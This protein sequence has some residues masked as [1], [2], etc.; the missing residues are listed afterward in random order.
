M[1]LG[2]FFLIASVTTGD[3]ALIK[4]SEA[5]AR[6]DTYT[7]TIKSEGTAREEIRYFFRKPGWIRMEFEEPHR[8]AVLV[9]NPDL[10]RVKL[11]PFAF[12]KYLVM[13]LS[14]EDRLIRSSKGHTVD[15]S[16]IG[17]LLENVE[18]LKDAGEA[19]LM[20][21]ESLNGRDTVVLEV[22]GKEGKEVNGVHRY[23]IWLD[24]RLF[25]PIKISSYALGGVKTEDVDMTDIEAGS[26]LPMDLF[27]FK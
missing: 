24:N 14:P 18:S 7:V 2:L 13:D 9:Y 20:G 4:A 11:R 1:L 25:L 12:F 19:R 21:Q 10:K 17:A 23:V 16:H 15:K 22:T 3:E 27:D 6:L 26:Y 8:G 5:F